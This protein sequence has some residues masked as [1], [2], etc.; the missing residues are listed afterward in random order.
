[1]FDSYERKK[2]IMQRIIFY[3]KTKLRGCREYYYSLKYYHQFKIPISNHL[4]IGI[5]T[6]GKTK[7][8]YLTQ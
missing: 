4:T 2:G 8:L 7:L 6:L 3:F 1:M 5:K